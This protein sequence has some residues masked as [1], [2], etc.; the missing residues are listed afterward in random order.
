MYVHTTILRVKP[1]NVSKAAEILSRIGTS[2]YSNLTKGIRHGFLLESNDEPGKLVSLSFW[3]SPTDAQRVFA[4]PD[5]AALIADLRDYLI[6]AP[7]RIGYS[8]LLNLPSG[9]Q[10]LAE[11]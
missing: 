5:Y 6:A 1:E 11:A 10:I 8:L 9:K 7:E 3:G 2:E 4:N